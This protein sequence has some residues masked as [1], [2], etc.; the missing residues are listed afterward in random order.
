MHW[1]LY[2]QCIAKNFY[3]Y[4]WHIHWRKYLL[5]SLETQGREQFRDPEKN[6]ALSFR[7][8]DISFV[9]MSSEASLVDWNVTNRF[10]WCLW[11]FRGW[12]SLRLRQVIAVYCHDVQAESR[13][14][15]LSK[16]AVGSICRSSGSP[17][18]VHAAVTRVTQQGLP[19]LPSMDFFLSNHWLLFSSILVS[20]YCFVSLKIQHE[21]H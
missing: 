20:A 13:A 7:E 9:S 19:S 16:A 8:R 12:G 3:C 11:L 2:T 15:K 1:G 18:W 21:Q 5:G 10:H 17:G 6:R 14:R 4:F